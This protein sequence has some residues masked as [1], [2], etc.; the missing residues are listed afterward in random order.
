[1]GRW[2]VEEKASR[3][4]LR[5]G[6]GAPQ[7]FQI[8]GADSLRLVDTLGQ[9]IGSDLWLVRAPQVDPVRDTMRLRGMF[10][11]MADAG[12][13]TECGSGATFPV[14]LVGDNAALERAYGGARTE[15]GAPLLVSF[16]GHLEERPAMEGPRRME[17]V[18]VDRFERV[19][20]GATCEGRMSNATLENTYWRLL[21]LG[22]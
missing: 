1:L 10:S 19:W 8:V 20:P 11:Y 6:P 22:G 12:R 21:E 7:V 14:A 2:S 9:P 13:F 17:H 4:V 16:T 5:T 15:P 3:L 18:V